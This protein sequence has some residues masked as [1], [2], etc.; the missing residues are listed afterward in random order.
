MRSIAAAAASEDIAQ[1]A[2]FAYAVCR[3]QD[4]GQV[5]AVQDVVEDP[6]LR[7]AEDEQ[8]D[9]YPQATVAAEVSETVH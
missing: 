2:L 3:R 1:A 5:A 8:Q 6:A 9:K 7:A 4:E